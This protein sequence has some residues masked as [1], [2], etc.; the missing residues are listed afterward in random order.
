[1]EEVIGTN[2]NFHRLNLTRGSS[3]LPLPSWISREKVI[4]NPKN[5]ECFKWAVITADRWEEIGNN[6]ERVSKLRRFECEYDWSDLEYPFAIKPIDKSGKKNKI[7]VYILMMMMMI[8]REYSFT[9][10]QLVTIRKVVNLMLI[11]GKNSFP[12]KVGKHNRKYYIAMKLLSRL[13]MAKNNKHEK[14]QYHCMNCLHGFPT[15]ASRDKHES[16]CQGV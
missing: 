15:E 7:S 5:L 3:N 1:M 13:V 10:S 14:V 9:E 11:T 4:I 16:Y 6:P 8:V 12:S 2:V